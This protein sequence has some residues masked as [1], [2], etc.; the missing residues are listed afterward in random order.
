MKNQLPKQFVVNPDIA[1]AQENHVP[2]VALE[3][4]VITH[5]L[6]Y[7]DNLN[8]A[9]DMEKIIR[10]R[11]A[12]PATIG[13]IGGKI[14]IGLSSDQLNFLAKGEVPVRKVG[15]RDLG[16]VIARGENG[17]TTVSGTLVLA[18]WAGIKVFSTGGI[19]GVH[20][21]S[22][23]DI[24][25]DLP[26][27][28]R[29]P[30]AVVCA[31]AKAILD[32][33]A[34]LEYLETTGVPVVG[35]QTDEFPAFYSRSSGM[36]A[37]VRVDSPEEVVD[38]ANAQWA[39]NIQRAV[40]VV[41]PVPQEEAILPEEVEK[42]IRQATKEAE[43][44]NITGYR[45]TPFLLKRVSELSGGKSLKANLALLKNN[46]RVGADIAIAFQKLAPPHGKFSS[47]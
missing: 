25:A 23:I 11:G 32:L 3:S 10:D 38:I 33:P 27:L 15:A 41:N 14:H 46:A 24:S 5:G 6:P 31:G 9:L 18:H 26:E 35:Y 43:E 4:T 34:T 22:G 20:R 40:L 44:Q 17:G 42:H 29:T 30:M 47:V 1:Q 13:V 45:V 36:K 19:G 21:G 12:V 39:L 8:L 28:G 2:I 37:Q 16:V 7:P